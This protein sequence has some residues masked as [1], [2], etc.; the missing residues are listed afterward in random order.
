MKRYNTI[1]FYLILVLP[2]CAVYRPYSETTLA[3]GDAACL[4]WLYKTEATLDEYG[5]TDSGTERIPSF[6]H[7][8]INRFLA[9]LRDLVLSEASYAQWLELMR[10]LDFKSKRMEAAN[11]P[12]PAVR[13]LTSGMPMNRTFDQALREC[14]KRLNAL[15]L[16][17]AEHKKF[18]LERAVVPDAYQD[19]KRIAGAYPLLQYAASLAI[20][21]LHSKLAADFRTPPT[22]LPLQGRPIRYVPTQQPFLENRDVAAM[23]FKASRNAMAIPMLRES[24]LQKLIQ[25]FAPVWEIDT[26]NDTDRIGSVMLSNV[27]QPKIDINRPVVYVSHAYTRFHGKILLQLIY[28]VW[29][30]AREKTGM[31]D[32]YGGELDSVIWRVTLSPEGKPLAYD[33]IHGCGCY[34]MLFPNDG[35]K[36]IQPKDGAER[37]LSPKQIKTLAPGQRLLLRLQTRTHYLRQVAPWDDNSENLMSNYKIENADRLRNLPMPDG[38]RRS[39]FGEDGIIDASRRTER[40]LL[41]PFGVASPGAMRQ[42]GTHAIAFTGKRHFD[43][44]FLLEK[45]LEKQ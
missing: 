38:S 12:P 4:R 35:Y 14:G 8:R 40:F 26:R 5:V 18:T 19:W 11:L 17:S 25:Q 20:G 37:V 21:R 36:A 31:L 30:P 9:S 33:S 23:L 22:L 1:I 29:L 24:Q 42:W 2:G 41:W 16:S 3:P 43:D 44:P 39:L 15:S 45:L 7:L 6:P 32:L 34:Y 13:S 27:G 10:Q 28:Q